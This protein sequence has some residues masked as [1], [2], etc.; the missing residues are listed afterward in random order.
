MRYLNNECYPSCDGCERQLPTL[1]S[2]E[3]LRLG[4]VIYG[5][6][7]NATNNHFCPMCTEKG[8]AWIPPANTFTLDDIKGRMAEYDQRG[9]YPGSTMRDLKA[10]LEIASELQTIID[11]GWQ[12]SQ[13]GEKVMREL[14]E[15]QQELEWALK[16][17]AVLESA[18]AP[19]AAMVHSDG[20][21]APYPE[22]T[23]IPLLD[24][25]HRAVKGD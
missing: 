2:S 9:I 5:G 12:L 14:G 10:L 23:W 18:L 16:R 24:A 17:I 4:W 20:V 22:E 8:R 25:A 19:F 13:A 1:E 3:L 6:P 11:A 7:H 21:E 15:T